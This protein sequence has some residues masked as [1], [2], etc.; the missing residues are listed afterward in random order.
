M[1]LHYEQEIKE[2]MVNK[3]NFNKFQYNFPFL[4]SSDMNIAIT[5]YIYN[6]RN[7]VLKRFSNSWDH[8]KIIKKFIEISCIIII[9]NVY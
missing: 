6:I 5:T 8:D 7:H 9:C 3:I 1:I 2:S 4:F